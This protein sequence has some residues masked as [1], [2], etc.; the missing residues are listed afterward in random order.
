[1]QKTNGKISNGIYLNL[2]WQKKKK[3]YARPPQNRVFFCFY[4]QA[5]VSNLYLPVKYLLKN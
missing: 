3:N 4:K 1:M 5:L 2:L